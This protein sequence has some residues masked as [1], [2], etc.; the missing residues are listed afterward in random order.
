VAGGDHDHANNRDYRIGVV[1]NWR[2][3]SC[4]GKPMSINV[5][6]NYYKTGPA[7]ANR[8]NVRFVVVGSTNANRATPS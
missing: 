3:R 6:N 8:G 4:D 1:Y 7:S 5:V 2:H